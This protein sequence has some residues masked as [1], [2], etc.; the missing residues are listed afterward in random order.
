M[1]LCTHRGEHFDILYAQNEAT[2]AEI[3]P[4]KVCKKI[5]VMGIKVNRFESRSEGC[6]F[7]KSQIFSVHV[8][9]FAA[10]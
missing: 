1:K 3:R 5:R 9:M 7:S 4:V 10:P 2:D 8:H 6:F